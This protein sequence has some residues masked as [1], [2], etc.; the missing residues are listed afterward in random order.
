MKHIQP[1]PG[2]LVEIFDVVNSDGMGS[3]DGG[4]AVAGD[5]HIDVTAS[6]LIGL[7]SKVWEITW[8]AANMLAGRE[9]G[10]EVLLVVL[11]KVAVGNSA[12]GCQ[13]GAAVPRDDLYSLALGWQSETTER[14][15]CPLRHGAVGGTV[16]VDGCS[17]HV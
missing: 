16:G 5:G 9:S 13:A 1:P 3:G 8:A 6:V 15:T 2:F 12:F 10:A 4:T 11:F 17:W 14:Q 7:G